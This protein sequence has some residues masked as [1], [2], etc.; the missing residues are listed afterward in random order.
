MKTKSYNVCDRFP[1]LL[2]AAEEIEM[3][4]RIQT[5]QELKQKPKQEL[6]KSEL[7]QLKRG[8]RALN[9]R[10]YTGIVNHLSFDDI[11][12]E[13]NVGLCR[14]AEKYDPTRGYKFSTYAYWWIR[15]SINRAISDKERVVRIPCN[16]FESIG[17]ALSWQ[18]EFEQKHG[19]QPTI[20]QVAAHIRIS[21]EVLMSAL[22]AYWRGPSLDASAKDKNGQTGGAALVDLFS[23]PSD[24]DPLDEI[25]Y[26]MQ[27]EKLYS[28]VG[29]LPDVQKE[30][31]GEYY[32]LFGQDPVSFTVM[33][34]KRG[35][36]RE[37]I[38]Q[39]CHRAINALSMKARMLQ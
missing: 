33:G 19:H 15:Q 31:L 36:S 9:A 20:N 32:G 3:G 21:P 34:K 26:G 14:A 25:E 12:Q 39:K 23:N 27:R 18:Q 10:K 30:L 7:I 22:R 2:T 8:Q 1:P 16:A 35:V 28:M 5:M 11:I 13:G 17:R 37:A 24:A 6:T 4:R 29:T 38:S